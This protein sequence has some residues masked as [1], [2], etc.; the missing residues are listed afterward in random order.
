MILS[1]ETQK[2]TIAQ[3]LRE[4]ISSIL[5]S[6]PAEAIAGN[7]SLKDHGADSVDRVEIILSIMNRLGIVEPMSSFS[8]ISTIDEMVAYL[9]GAR[10]I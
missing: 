10:R 1:S 7:R 4:T 8:N 9:C 5:P 3:V 6:L 2:E